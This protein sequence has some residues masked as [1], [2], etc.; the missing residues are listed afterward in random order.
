[1]HIFAKEFK[2]L[3]RD[4]GV[5]IIIVFAPIVYPLLYPYLYK[6]E[7][8]VNVPIA[9]V[10]HSNTTRSAEFIA[11][12]DATMDLK[13]V[14]KPDNFRTSRAEIYQ[15]NIH[16]IIYIPEDFNK[17]I[18]N[19]QQAFISMYSDMSSFLYYRAMVLG[20]NYVTLDMGEK[21]KIQRLND[22]G[23]SGHAAEVSAKP[24]L[25]EGTIL[26]NPG[27][28][29]T[30][31]LLTAVLIIMLHQTLVFGIGM[32]AGAERE[33]N[34]N[35]ELI[36][37][38]TSRGGLFR[39]IL[40]RALSYF[41]LYL[42]WSAF[43]LLVVPR[44][45]NLPHIGDFHTILSFVVPFLLA[46]I[47]FSMTLSVFNMERETQ[48]ILFVFFSL[49]L[50]FLS[51]ISWPQSNMSGFWRV[52]SYLFPSTFGVQGFIKSNTMGATP[53]EIRFE[54]A[55]L[56]IQTLVYFITTTVL[57]YRGIKRNGKTQLSAT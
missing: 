7:T 17:K 39:V 45:F 37:S 41:T 21:V 29:F 32:A 52:F 44:I 19:R 36:T 20:V 51:G 1:M 11:G 28:G 35:H 38:T 30:S 15:G 46:T 53:A 27:M 24:M 6:N 2:G 56:W 54:T 12:L 4:R 50:L 31:F 5:M 47:F 14:A 23:I 48:M 16:G 22:L 10:D 40:G 33:D 9:V 18:T 42:F 26:F 8:I 43:M 34:P 25:N 3:F 55:G 57:Y 49:I 13:V